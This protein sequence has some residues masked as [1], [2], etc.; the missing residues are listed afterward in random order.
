MSN[1]LVYTV[2]IVEE[3]IAEPSAQTTGDEQEAMDWF[4]NAASEVLEGDSEVVYAKVEVDG[5]LWGEIR[6]GGLVPPAGGGE[7]VPLRRTRA[8]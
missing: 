8:A 3:D 1:G 6:E 7:V 5:V 4:T 2:T